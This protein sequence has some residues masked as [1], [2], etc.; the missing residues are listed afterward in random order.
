M[1]IPLP[2]L[3][4]EENPDPRRNELSLGVT[5]ADEPV[6]GVIVFLDRVALRKLSLYELCALA[7]DNRADDLLLYLEVS[8]LIG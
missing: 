7:A 4:E 3:L 5:C 1:A 8:I 2:V 6:C